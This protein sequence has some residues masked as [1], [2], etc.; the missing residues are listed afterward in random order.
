MTDDDS[1]GG[2]VQLALRLPRALLARVD[3]HA[4]RMRAESPGVSVTRS[5]AMRSL[6][7]MSLSRV[8][9]SSPKRRR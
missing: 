1:E 9:A 8:E 4:D 7:I 6:L 3:A 2:S 5:D